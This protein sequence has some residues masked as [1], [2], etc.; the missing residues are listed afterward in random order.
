MQQCTITIICGQGNDES[1]INGGSFSVSEVDS[2]LMSVLSG[3][4]IQG[5]GGPWPPKSFVI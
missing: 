3:G 4:S 5:L 1:I 2:S